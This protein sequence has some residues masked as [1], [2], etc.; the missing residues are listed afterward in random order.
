VRR[1]EQCYIASKRDSDGWPASRAQLSS[2][3]E[4]PTPAAANSRFGVSFV[5][6]VNLSA[7]QQW[8][9]GVQ[10]A[11]QHRGIGL[12][13]TWVRSLEPCHTP[14]RGVRGGWQVQDSWRPLIKTQ[15]KN[16]QAVSCVPASVK[17]QVT[18]LL[19][20]CPPPMRA[21]PKWKR[22]V[23]WIWTHI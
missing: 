1:I 10:K 7:E 2:T 11:A 15:A 17:V 22:E 18:L 20:L 3:A 5:Q 4:E 14:T 6:Q 16:K 13:S 12:K 9:Q 23:R 21:T 8:Y 19:L